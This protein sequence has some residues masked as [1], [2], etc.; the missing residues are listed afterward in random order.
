MRDT[1]FDLGGIMTVHD[2]S[3]ERRRELRVEHRGTVILA[4]GPN[5]K[6]EFEDAL[7]LDCSGHGIRIELKRRLDVGAAFLVKPSRGSTLML[8]YKVRRCETRGDGFV[9]GAEYCGFVSAGDATL[10]SDGVLKIL[11]GIKGAEKSTITDT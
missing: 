7:M 3:D 4:Y 2:K 8:Q 5:E 1:S 9:I 6:M 11:L 10:D